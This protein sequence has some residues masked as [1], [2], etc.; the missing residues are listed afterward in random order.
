MQHP[1]PQNISTYEFRLIGDMTL[2]Q[3]MQLA[4]G[5]GA[6]ILI[7][8]TNLFTPIKLALAALFGLGGIGVAFVPLEERSLDKWLLAFIKSIY[9]PTEYIWRKDHQMP[10][11]FNFK[12]STTT[13]DP[14]EAEELMLAAVKRKQEGL[15]SYLQTL[16]EHQLANQIETTESSRLDSIAQLLTQDGTI[17]TATQPATPTPIKT[18]TPAL[19]NVNTMPS[20]TI[21]NASVA[22]INNAAAQQQ[23]PPTPSSDVQIPKSEAVEIEKQSDTQTPPLNIEATMQTPQPQAQNL[24]VNRATPTTVAPAKTNDKLPFPSTPTSPNTIVGMVLDSSQNIVANAIIEI[25]DGSG[26]PA[27]AT[28]TNKLGQF[29]STTPLK[30][31]EYQI[32][33]EKQGLTFDILSLHLTGQ[34]VKPLKIVAHGD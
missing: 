10:E 29:F 9:N 18:P 31:G 17:N 12:P 30:D 20:N 6:A 28:K 22:Q 24:S 27:R 32:E 1:I 5:L 15:S 33:I 7:Y 23:T 13:I 4:V 21:V 34:I 2:K 3:F 16:P 26:V 11:Y 14:Q 25:K 19:I 8:S